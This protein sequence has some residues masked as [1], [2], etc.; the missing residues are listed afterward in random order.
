MQI[1]TKTLAIA[2]FLTAGAANAGTP[3]WTLSESAGSVNVLRAGVSKIAVTG[4]ILQPGDIVAAGAKSRAVLVRGEEYVAVSP[5]SRV[6]ISEP[7]AEGGVM[8]FFQEVGNAIFRIDKKATP[9]FGV[10]TPYL[11]AVVKG[12]T[13]SITV[14]DTG[15]AIQVTEGSVQV[16][17][18]DGGATQLLSP[19]MIGMVE[20]G[21]QFRLTISGAETRTID[22]PNAPVGS[23]DT[24]EPMDEAALLVIATSSFEGTISAPIMETPV[25]LGAVTKGL[26]QGG[27]ASDQPVRLA[28]NGSANS[29]AGPPAGAGSNGNSGYGSSNAAP[30]VFGNSSGNGQGASGSG[31]E[32]GNSGEGNSGVGEGNGGGNGTGNEGNGAGPDSGNGNGGAGDGNG[33]AGNGG[34]G[35][36]NGGA[37]NG[38]GGAGGGNGGAGGGKP[39]P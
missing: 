38:N 36:G 2:A 7:K 21:K 6:R 15:A 31:N 17:T 32:N 26:V 4:S 5:N 28:F 9:H 20:R 12:T 10:E 8:Q 30:G 24:P 22:S 35:N 27:A 13:F 37:G 25:S 16:A 14:S 3:Q 34:A 39:T 19:G 18:L 1:L 23:T 29:N 11:A 33:G